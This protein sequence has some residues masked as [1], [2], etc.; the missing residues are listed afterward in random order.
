M[1][2]VFR[3]ILYLVISNYFFKYCNSEAHKNL[4]KIRVKI[5]DTKQAVLKINVTRTQRLCVIN[6]MI[7][8][9]VKI[10]TDKLLLD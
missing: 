8:S 3:V 9:T 2:I 6:V 7:F 4:Q 1:L 5:V 10:K